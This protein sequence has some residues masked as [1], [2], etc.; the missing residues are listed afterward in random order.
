M[1][2]ESG[3]VSGRHR[4]TFVYAARSQLRLHQLR[5]M[6]HG[7]A[8][9]GSEMSSD[10][11]RRLK[12][13]GRARGQTTRATKLCTIAKC[14]HK[15]TL[16]V[17]DDNEMTSASQGRGCH[18]LPLSGPTELIVDQLNSLVPAVCEHD[19]ENE[20]SSQ[21]RGATLSLYAQTNSP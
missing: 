20:E 4:L 5:G 2:S 11:R 18:L 8:S 17:I 15:S 12:W 16:V 3:A 13:L 10:T 7:R 1:S 19:E 21:Q 9:H 14:I 6:L